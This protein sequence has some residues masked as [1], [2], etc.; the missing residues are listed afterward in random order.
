MIF[1]MSFTWSSVL[2]LSSLVRCAACCTLTIAY[3]I[4]FLYSFKVFKV[5]VISTN[6]HTR[7]ADYREVIQLTLILSCEKEKSEYGANVLNSKSVML[8]QEDN[9]S[10]N[11]RLICQIHVLIYASFQSNKSNSTYYNLEL[12]SSGFLNGVYL[13]I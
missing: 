9:F 10:A 6:L 3:M 4:P 1:Q 7:I 2:S 11:D 13:L 8:T 12:G 5:H